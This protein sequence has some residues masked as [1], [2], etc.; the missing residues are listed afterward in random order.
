MVVGL[1]VVVTFAM[2]FTYRS[3]SRILIRYVVA[4]PDRGAATADPFVLAREAES[5]V[6]EE[7]LARVVGSGLR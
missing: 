1:T 7:V 6:S 3:E 2:P 4:A 5:A